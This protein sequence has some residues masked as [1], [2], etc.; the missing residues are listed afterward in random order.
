VLVLGCA[1]TTKVPTPPTSTPLA[2]TPTSLPPPIATSTRPARVPTQT[3]Q[4]A[5]LRTFHAL[6][7]FETYETEETV[8]LELGRLPGVATINVTQLDVTVQYDPSRLSEDEILRTLRDNPEV[9]IK[10]D[11]RAGQ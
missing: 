4:P 11:A 5:S 8:Q 6:I 3:P 7:S 2:P 9:R 1:Q 10:D